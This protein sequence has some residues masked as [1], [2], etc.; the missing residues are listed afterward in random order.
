[1]AEQIEIKLI[2]ASGAAQQAFQA[3]PSQQTRGQSPAAT[4]QRRGS[5][6]SGRGSAG[7]GSGTSG[8]ASSGSGS[9]APTTGDFA[10][11]LREYIARK[12]HQFIPTELINEIYSGGK[13]VAS[14]L[15]SMGK[16]ATTTTSQASATQQASQA[17]GSASNV[18]AAAT[19]SAGLMSKILPLLTN[20]I[21]LTIA[22]F[23]AAIGLS[24]AAIKL[25][26]G[27][28]SEVAENLM[29]LSPEIAQARAGR[30]VALEL[31]RLDRAQRVG[32][33][34]ARL[35]NANTRL[36]EAMYEVQTKILEAILE[37][38]P[39]ITSILDFITQG[40]AHADVI[41]KATTLIADLV[42]PAGWPHM[43][44]DFQALADAIKAAQKPGQPP[45]Q[46]ISIWQI[47][48]GQIA[49]PI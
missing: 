42:T 15:K 1:M 43:P 14:A 27:A 26:T 33:G 10:S 30:D 5:G 34:L 20:P 3:P 2:D 44:K 29:D 21:T 40:I 8:G 11:E 12:V 19:A 17:A 9:G 22:G 25:F 37:Y 13:L 23:T 38:E 39:L 6:T 28:M 41:A 45:V 49:N 18:A 24:V 47:L 35:E 48:Q 4:N 46:G 31:A 7:S 16:A 32:P 36:Q